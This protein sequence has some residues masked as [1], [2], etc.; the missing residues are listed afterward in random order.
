MINPRAKKKANAIS[1]GM[2]SPKAENAAAKVSVFVRTEAPRPIKATA[3]KGNGCVM[4]PTIV[5]KKME[6][7]CHAILETPE[8]GGRN[9]IITPVAMEAMSGLM[10]APCHGWG[11]GTAG[12]A[13][14]EADA[15][16]TI[17]SRLIRNLGFFLANWT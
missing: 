6:S 11:A 17:G 1:H 5:A 3:P 14:V 13:E 2:G 10:A 16:E 7:N 9:Q 4:I 12:T 15:A 8:G